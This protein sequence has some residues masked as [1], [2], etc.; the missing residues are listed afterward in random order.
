MGRKNKNEIMRQAISTQKK[1]MAHEEAVFYVGFSKPKIHF[2]T[3]F[4]CH[5]SF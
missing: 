1:L 5:V 4:P 2:V 3:F